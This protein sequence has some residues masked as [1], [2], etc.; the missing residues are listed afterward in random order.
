MGTGQYA[1][2]ALRDTLPRLRFI[3]TNMLDQILGAECLSEQASPTKK[4]PKFARLGP[5]EAA[6]IFSV[7]L[8][9]AAIDTFQQMQE[10]R[11]EQKK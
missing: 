9:F 8:V 2:M 10:K 11:E 3:P 6:V 7:L 1:K 5:V 4:S